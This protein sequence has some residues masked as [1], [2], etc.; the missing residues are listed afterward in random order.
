MVWVL[1]DGELLGFAI[2][3]WLSQLGF[4]VK[5]GSFTLSLPAV[6]DAERL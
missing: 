1:M 5:N 3:T 6:I 4:Q 2:R